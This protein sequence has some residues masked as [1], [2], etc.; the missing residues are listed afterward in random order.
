MRKL[1]VTSVALCAAVL[2]GANA[3]AQAPVRYAGVFYSSLAGYR[4]A[5]GQD[6]RTLQADP[7]FVSSAAGDFR[8]QAGSPAAGAADA[9][10]PGWPAG[11]A[12]CP[13]AE[14]EA[15]VDARLHGAPDSRR[16]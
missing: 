3:N 9:R 4:A 1:V 5:S 12:G 6:G 16:P 10:G 13:R 11:E 8:L 15:E 2:F 14:V 7:R